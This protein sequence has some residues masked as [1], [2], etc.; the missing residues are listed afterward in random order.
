MW[1]QTV[2]VWMQKATEMEF[3][4]IIIPRRNYS[5]DE[6]LEAISQY[7]ADWYFSNYLMK[8]E[9]GT[10]EYYAWP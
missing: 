1:G 9:R 7:V 5:I 2:R 3:S 8:P 4:G 10:I 6:K